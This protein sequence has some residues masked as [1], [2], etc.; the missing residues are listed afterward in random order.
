MKK[1][2]EHTELSRNE[3]HAPHVNS[4][5]ARDNAM[6]IEEYRRRVIKERWLITHILSIHLEIESFMTEL[7][8][9][10]LP[11]PEKL[12]GKDGQKT[13]FTQKLTLCEALNVVG[14]DL[15]ISIRALNKLRNESA[16]V[17][18]YILTLDDIAKFIASMSKMHPLRVTTPGAR[19]KNLH[20]LKQIRNHIEQTDREEIELFV[21]ISL[22]LLKAKVSSL[23]KK[24]IN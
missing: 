17:P 11:K 20:N 21:F 19:S 10:I 4:K 24:E 22:L 7:L 8:R 12:F 9:Q 23:C 2:I 18:G 5:E 16:H 6:R 13:T 14:Q 15:A 3:E 1:Q